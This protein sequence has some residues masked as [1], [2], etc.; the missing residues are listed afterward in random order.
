METMK[1]RCRKKSFRNKD[2]IIEFGVSSFN[3]VETLHLCG[4]VVL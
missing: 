3:L 2:E 4:V 1:V